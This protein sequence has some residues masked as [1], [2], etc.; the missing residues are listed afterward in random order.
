MCHVRAS[1]RG[2]CQGG[3]SSW[4]SQS[5]AG[6]P[7]AQ[8]L[9]CQYLH[10]CT[11]KASKVSRQSSGYSQFCACVPELVSI[12]HTSAYVSIHASSMWNLSAYVSIRQHWPACASSMWTS[13]AYVSIRQHTSAYVSIRQHTS[14]Y[15]PRACGTCQPVRDGRADSLCLLLVALLPSC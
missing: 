9:W 8:L 6:V 11:S 10:F 2:G 1:S 4:H 5:C 13:S 7:A 14:A 15:M 12:Q 3:P